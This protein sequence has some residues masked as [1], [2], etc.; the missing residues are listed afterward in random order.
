[1]FWWETE[2]GRRRLVLEKAAMLNVFPKAKLLLDRG[3]TQLFWE[4]DVDDVPNQNGKLVHHKIKVT[5]PQERYPETAPT[6]AVVEPYF[7]E[8]PHKF[9]GGQLCLF[10]PSEGRNHGWDPAK[11]TGVTIALWSKEWIYAYYSWRETGRWPGYQESSSGSGNRQRERGV[12]DV[13]GI[14]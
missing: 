12:D 11:S 3:R 2:D 9:G 10:N 4:I 8:S 1:M 6:G 7:P 14:L 5:Y 13:Q